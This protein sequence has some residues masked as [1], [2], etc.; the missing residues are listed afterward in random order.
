[1]GLDLLKPMSL[2]SSILGSPPIS[3]R[4]ILILYSSLRL[5]LPSL[6]K[7]VRIIPF[8]IARR[9]AEIKKPTSQQFKYLKGKFIANSKGRGIDVICSSSGVWEG[10]RKSSQAANRYGAV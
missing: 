10:A 6:P 5:D 3:L 7:A 8:R 1:L 2:V 9:N 4:Y